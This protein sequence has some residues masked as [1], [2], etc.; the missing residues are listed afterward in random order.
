MGRE[1]FSPGAYTL[2][3]HKVNFRYLV[4]GIVPTYIYYGCNGLGR[5]TDQGEPQS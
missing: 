4:R 2:I 3:D 5:T 1:L